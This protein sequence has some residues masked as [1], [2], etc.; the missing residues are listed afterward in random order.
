MSPGLTA[1]CLIFMALALCFKLGSLL[2]LSRYVHLLETGAQLTLMGYTLPPARQSLEVLLAVAG[3]CL[4]M[5]CTG[6]LMHYAAEIRL[7]RLAVLFEEKCVSRGISLLGS[8]GG[9]SDLAGWRP[10]ASRL[11]STDARFSGTIARLVLKLFLPIATGSATLAM[12]VYLDPVLTSTIF[13]IVVASIP[14]IYRANL[15]GAGHSV[16]LERHTPQANVRKRAL[17]HQIADQAVEN[18]TG[19][20]VDAAFQV[21]A[22]RASLDAYQGRL[23][24]TEESTLVTALVMGITIFAILLQK[25]GTIMETGTGWGALAAYLLLLRVCLGSMAQFANI[26]TAVNRLYPQ[27]SR[28]MSFVLVASKLKGQGVFSPVDRGYWRK[29]GQAKAGGREDFDLD[30]E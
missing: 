13:V 1:S 11:I 10:N 28:Y 7:L 2:L 16:M 20:D 26:L 21:G 6:S 17:I 9:H 19:V 29:P 8:V 3:A 24:A 25:G 30:D 23:R 18:T 14:L 15:R 12:L 4:T 5:F 22:L 27:L